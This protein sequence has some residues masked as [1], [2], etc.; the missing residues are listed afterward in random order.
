MKSNKV[1]FLLSKAIN[2]S[3][4]SGDGHYD[5]KRNI[6]IS[7]VNDVVVPT[8]SIDNSILTQSKTF[9][10]PTDDD[11]DREAESCF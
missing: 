2:V 4:K 8:V 3:A 10:A 11:P 5:D 1:N 6:N 7:L 9:V